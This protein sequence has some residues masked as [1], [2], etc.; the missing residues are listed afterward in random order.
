MPHH[1][2]RSS[3]GSE[4]N[5]PWFI[6]PGLVCLD[7]SILRG[8]KEPDHRY[9][10]IAIAIR[11]PITCRLPKGY[12][13]LLSHVIFPDLANLATQERIVSAHADDGQNI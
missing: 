11:Q 5:P 13:M 7:G 4:T 6:K 2:V 9:S 12:S 10:G 8:K 3:A 1:H